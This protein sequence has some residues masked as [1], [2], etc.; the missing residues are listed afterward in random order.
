MVLQEMMKKR[1]GRYTDDFVWNLGTPY[2]GSGTA[3]FAVCFD[4]NV[5]VD[6][7]YITFDPKSDCS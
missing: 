3:Q 2:M 5:F 6:E 1:K 4:Y 7:V